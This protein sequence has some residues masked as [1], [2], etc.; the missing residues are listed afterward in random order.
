MRKIVYLIIIIFCINIQFSFAQSIISGVVLSEQDGSPIPGATIFAKG[1]TGLGT[2]TDLDGKFT[3]K[4]PE[5]VTTILV[6]FVGMKSQEIVITGKQNITVSLKSED[7]GL[8]DVVVTAMG[9]K[10]EKKAL[11]YAVQEVKGGELAKSG[12]NSLDNSLQGKISGIEIRQ[13]SGMPG[14]SSQIM[15]RGAR[16]LTGTNQPL[17]VVDGMPIESGSA[18]AVDISGTDQTNRTVDIDPNDIESLS[19]LKGPAAAALYGMRASNGVVVITTKSGKNAVVGKPVITFFSNESLDFVSKLPSR[20]QKYAQGSDGLFDPSS[21]TSWGPA[22]SDLVNDPIY[23]QNS[24]HNG[25]G[26]PKGQYFVPQSSQWVVPQYYDNQEKFFQTG[27]NNN[28][29]VSIS[30][31]GALGDYSLGLSSTNQKGVVPSTGMSRNS[32]RLS[33]NFDL[34]PGLKLGANANYSNVSVDKQPSGSSYSNPL[35]A[36]YASPG[37][38]DLWGNPIHVIGQPYSQVNYRDHADNPR[39]ALDNNKF[40]EE[41][42]RFFGNINVTYNPL[43]WLNVHYQLG[44]DQFTTTGKEIYALGSGETAGSGK[45]IDQSTVQKQLNSNFN[46]TISKELTSDLKFNLLLGNEIVDYDQNQYETLS[47]KLDIGGFGNISNGSSRLSTQYLYRK[48]TFGLFENLALE[49]KS[50]LYFNA[51]GRTDI[52]S[53]MPHGNRTFFYPSASLGFVFTE[54]D[55][56]KDLKLLPYGKLRFSFAQVGQAGPMYSDRSKYLV[57]GSSSGFIAENSIVYPFNA[58]NT[59]VPSPRLNNPNLKPQNTSTFELGTEFK[60]WDGRISVDYTY[61]KAIITDQ[62]FDVPTAA[63]SGYTIAIRNAGKVEN[64]VHELSFTILPLKTV[65]YELS[66]TANF[67]K[68]DNN[69]IELASG[70]T[71]LPLGGFT[72]PSI[73]AFAGYSF[74]VIYGS[75]FLRDSKGRIVI[76]DDRTSLNYGMP[77]QSKDTI[78]GRVSPNYQLSFNASFRYKMFTISALVDIKNGGQIFSG[79]NSLMLYNGMDARTEDRTTPIKLDG[80]K[81]HLVNGAL[82]SDGAQNDIGVGGANSPVYQRYY[83][84][85]NTIDESG[86]YSTSYIKLREITLNI[87]IPKNWLSKLKISKANVSLNARNIWTKTDYPNLDPEASQGNGN[88]AGGIEYISLPQIKSYGLGINL[89]F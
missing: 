62:I 54:I 39:W 44:I 43:K 49:Y 21:S 15:I 26:D 34:F 3:L 16:S 22:I 64:K 88:M 10:R 80:V 66:I 9:I 51:S 82:V 1:A 58:I 67:S 60:F 73:R 23:G 61:S 24:I 13:S 7:I 36:L 20:Q 14:A 6:T 76:N 18:Y 48:R 83:T 68:I 57:G 87:D 38:Y 71:N 55:A 52:V 11:G 2:V 4:V 31:A 27:T 86:V 65:D 69:I 33:V 81:G 47:T 19:V 32:A 63:S 56:L 45:I 53:N 42:N 29:G 50:M 70:V 37:S 30:Q 89:T 35:F 8:K 75:S 46:I 25:T 74:P 17:Y 40:N 85:L 72:T 77:I 59:Y 84:L 41:T 12:G 28:T 5:S 78:I 79:T